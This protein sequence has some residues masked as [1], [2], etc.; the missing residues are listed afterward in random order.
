MVQDKAVEKRKLCAYDKK[1]T[2]ADK[3]FDETVDFFT[4]LCY[5]KRYSPKCNDF[6]GLKRGFGLASTL[7]I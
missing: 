7:I 1:F 5:N 2:S 4:F 6:L 3:K